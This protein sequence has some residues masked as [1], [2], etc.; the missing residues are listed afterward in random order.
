MSQ[1]FFRDPKLSYPPCEHVC[2]STNGHDASKGRRGAQPWVEVS[3]A[4]VRPCGWLIGDLHAGM[5]ELERIRRETEAAMALLVAAAPETRDSVASLAR[6]CGIGSREARRRR[7]VARVTE[8]VSGA[9][10]LLSSGAVSA[11]HV[12][13]MAP[14][15][16]MEGAADLL[17]AARLKSPED[18][19]REVEPFGLAAEHGDDVAKR[20]HAR[21]SF[22]F[23]PGPD[24]MLGLSGLLPP[25][26]G[27]EFKNRMMALVDARWREQHPGRSEVLGGHGGDR[28]AVR[29]AD[30]S[31]TI[32]DRTSRTIV[33]RS[34]NPG[35]AA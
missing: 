10:G 26:E 16:E 9:L 34:R 24:G 6:T 11:D 15:A 4:M 17:A 3:V 2:V 5:R 32:L 21:R 30:G 12:A 29:E 28:V 13:A 1:N 27:T 14:V 31:I 35:V 33:I 19:A 7:D 20:Q 25:V 18:L 8:K 22:R 23:F